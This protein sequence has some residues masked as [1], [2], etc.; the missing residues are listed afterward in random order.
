MVLL[1]PSNRQDQLQR[2]VYC[3]SLADLK[4]K[5][6]MLRLNSFLNE[7]G[8]SASDEEGE[9]DARVLVSTSETSEALLRPVPVHK[10][11]CPKE[12]CTYKRERD[13]TPWV[14]CSSCGQ[15]FHCRCVGLTKQQAKKSSMIIII[16]IKQS[17]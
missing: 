4:R 8:D 5:M 15:W 7:S 1:P 13:G 2:L 3:L 14:L 17:T 6:H 9:S 16:I 11:K 12:T 10:E